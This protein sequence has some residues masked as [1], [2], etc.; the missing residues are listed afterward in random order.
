MGK[1]RFEM[2]PMEPVGRTDGHR[3]QWFAIEHGFDAGISARRDAIGSLQMLPRVGDR[4]RAGTGNGG[5][6]VP[7][8]GQM[9]CDVLADSL[10]ARPRPDDADPKFDRIE[11]VRGTWFC[12]KRK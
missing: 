4:L 3:I 2:L 11:R 12:S 7:E 10:M 6:F 5:H 8:R 1:G 9:P